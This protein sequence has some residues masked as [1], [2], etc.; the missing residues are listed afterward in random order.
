MTRFQ[1][2]TRSSR[3]VVALGACLRSGDDELR[4]IALR[5]IESVLREHGGNATGAAK[6]LGTPHRTMCRWMQDPGV[7]ALVDASRVQV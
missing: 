7:K 1:E 3:L 6:A 4:N 5:R 2:E